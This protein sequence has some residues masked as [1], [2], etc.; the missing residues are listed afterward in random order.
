MSNPIPTFFLEDDQ[1]LTL[2]IGPVD[3]A[4]NPAQISGI[5]GWSASDNSILTLKPSSDGLS[6]TVASNGKIGSANVL[7]TLGSLTGNASFTIHSGAAVG[8]GFTASTPA[9]IAP[10]APPAETP[11]SG[12]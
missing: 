11:A 2:T 8:F 1:Q 10:A 9:T 3:A 5:P 12:S 6:C 7:V 4:G